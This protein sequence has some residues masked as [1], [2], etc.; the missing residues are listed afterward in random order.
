MTMAFM[1]PLSPEIRNQPSV[2]WNLEFQITDSRC[3]I[4][5]FHPKSVA[6]VHDRRPSA[7]RLLI[8]GHRPPLQ[9]G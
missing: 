9:Y 4:L 2:I 8:G 1:E 5:D 7:A 6:A 3:P